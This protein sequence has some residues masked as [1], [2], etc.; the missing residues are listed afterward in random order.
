MTAAPLVWVLFA[1]L[2]SLSAELFSSL[3]KVRKSTATT[4]ISLI[5]KNKPTA[6][7][8]QAPAFLL[9][10]VLVAF[11]SLHSFRCIPFALMFA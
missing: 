7:Q 4:Y 2:L 8:Y 9:H 1:P 6:V 11:L 5:F 10:S 3:R